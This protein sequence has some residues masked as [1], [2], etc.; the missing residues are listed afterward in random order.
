MTTPFTIVWIKERSI[1][2]QCVFCV[3]T[4]KEAYRM[5]HTLLKGKA[6]QRVP[7]AP[8]MVYRSVC[9]VQGVDSTCVM[10]VMSERYPDGV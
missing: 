9:Q 7:T 10:S 8:T 6:D 2:V 3:L 1:F 5:G 4:P